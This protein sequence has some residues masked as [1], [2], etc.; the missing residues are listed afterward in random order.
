MVAVRIRTDRRLWSIPGLTADSFFSITVYQESDIVNLAG[1]EAED[2]W[3]AFDVNFENTLTAAVSKVIAV[4]LYAQL[5][6]D[7]EIDRR[8]RLKETL[9]LGFVF[10]MR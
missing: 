2:Y 6:Y 10:R 5:L 3:R 4:S 8:T 1:T 9:A 7:K